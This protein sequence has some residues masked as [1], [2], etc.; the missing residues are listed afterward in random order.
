MPTPGASDLGEYFD[1]GEAAM[2]DVQQ[3][4][5]VDTTGAHSGDG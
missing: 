3:E 2:P 1:F 5:I 4:A